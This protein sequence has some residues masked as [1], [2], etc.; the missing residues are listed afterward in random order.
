MFQ[1]VRKSGT[2]RFSLRAVAG[3][4]KACLAGDFTGWQP[5]AMR[6]RNAVFS[7]TLPVQPGRHEY[8]FILD[9]RWQTDPDH[10][11]WAANAYGTVNSVITAPPKGRRSSY[12]GK[13]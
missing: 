7:I 3:V 11:R 2:V 10:S 12:P 6:K 5:V 8:K 1:K 4:R 9:G 13:M